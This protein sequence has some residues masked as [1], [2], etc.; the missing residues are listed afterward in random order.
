[1]RSHISFTILLALLLWR[2]SADR[3]KEDITPEPGASVKNQN[4]LFK[5]L[6]SEKTHITFSNKLTEGPNTNI[7]MYEYFYNGGGVAAGD[8]NGDGLID[9]YFSS[10]MDNNSLYLNKGAM[11]FEDITQLS[12]AA[13]RTGPWKT[14]VTMADVN[15]DGKLDIYLCYSGAVRDENR[16]N[17]L[18][19]NEGNDEKG[20]PHFSERAKDFG[21]ASI[22]YSNQIYFLDLDLD[23]DLDAILLNHNPKSLPILNEI[24]TAALLKKDDPL[25][26]I[27]ILK[28]NNSVF[29]DVTLKSGVNGSELTYGLGVAISDY[30]NDG[31]PDFYVSNDYAVPDYLYINN[32]NGSFT[33]KLGESM[34][35]TSQ[36]SMGNDVADINNDG[37]QDVITLDMLPEDNRRQKQLMAADNYEKFEL[38]LRTGFHHQYMRNMLQ[39]NNGNNS[40]SEIGQYAGISNTDW[41]WSALLADYN[42]DGR[43]DLFV[44]NGYFRDYTNL[45]FIKYMDDFVKTRGRL[46]REEVLELIGHMPSSNV[47]NYIFS[48]TDSLKFN[49]KTKAWGLNMPSNSNGAAYADLDNDGDLDIVTNN[50]NQ[51]AFVL[52]NHS[53]QDSTKHHLGISLKGNGKNTIG[54]GAK[55]TASIGGKRQFFEQWC[56]RG[57]LSSVS[58]VINIG[59]GGNTMVDTLTIHWPT[60]EVQTM[61]H[62][63]ADQL[64]VLDQSKAK[65]ISK[66]KQ[67]ARKTWLSATVSPIQQSYAA[68]VINDFKRQALLIDQ[69]SFFGPCLVKGDINN[70]GLD[71]VFVGG[72]GNVSPKIFVQ[73]KDRTFA[74]PANL[75]LES[76][77][78]FND[79]DAVFFDANNDGYT[80]LY[81]ASGGY[82]GHQAGDSLLWDRLYINDGRGSLKKS[83]SLPR[84][85]GSKGCVSAGDINGDGFIDLFVG[86]RITP[87]RYPEAPSSYVLINDGKGNFSDVTG[88]LAP[89]LTDFG[90]ITTSAF[91]D[92]NGDNSKELIVA[93]EWTPITVFGMVNNK[94]ANITDQYFDREYVGW[95]NKIEIG[96]VNHDSIPDLV[97]GNMGTN[98][99][100]KASVEQPVEMYYHDFDGNGSVDGFLSYYIQ[101][102]SYPFVTRDELLDQLSGM[103]KRFTSYNSYGDITLKELFPPEEL[104]KAKHLVATDMR[105]ALFLGTRKGKFK[106]SELPAQAQFS[107]VYSIALSDV[108]GDSHVDMILCGN[109]MHTKIRIGN[110]D[111]NYGQLMLGDGLGKFRYVNQLESGLKLRGEVRSVVEVNNTFLFGVGEGPI[112]AYKKIR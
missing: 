82:H 72:H 47:F 17:Q 16:V 65:E 19:I 7:L 5:A 93:G 89:I 92:L 30:N 57:Y 105:T 98:N 69:P 59:L 12:G 91:A 41:S 42:N 73:R 78:V 2:C 70:D 74:A 75:A 63:K 112:Q 83:K 67:P 76:E 21:L 39:L 84:V 36:F 8:I 71:D 52:E 102:K 77:S 6:P 32:G 94:L 31:W 99:Q 15:G 29:S 1:M 49:N 37:W 66:Q 38:N 18:F 107:P 55:I 62:L 108:N 45:D 111:G 80:D 97:A 22:G 68:T 106:R 43:K 40:F 27:R 13:G 61:Y 104:K 88:M 54:L 44:T 14:G 35:H 9:L 109:D 95:W 60:R 103:R 50:I 100:L 64:V 87:G 20:L 34:G 110:S 46:K 48:G 56:T 90:M 26:G 33:D 86:G 81:I 10:N 3:P 58:P 24:N 101:D 79:A 53:E 23:G 85:S 96:D 11:V 25:R 51:A 28:N 4:T